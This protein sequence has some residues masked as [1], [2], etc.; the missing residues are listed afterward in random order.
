MQ[1]G[2]TLIETLIYI[3][4]LTLIIGGGVV[5][6]FYIIDASTKD[7]TDVGV[8]AEGNFIIKKMEWALTGSTINSV[9][10]TTLSLTKSGSVLTFSYAGGQYLRLN[11]SN[12]N[13][14]AVVVEP[15]AGSFFTDLPASGTKPRGITLNFTARPLN[16]TTATSTA[17]TSTKYLRK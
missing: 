2:F 1:R 15:V 11:G 4:L 13:N 12:L 17:F 14:S 6:S 7:K 5:S 16:V 10:T 8:Q 3:A 9:A